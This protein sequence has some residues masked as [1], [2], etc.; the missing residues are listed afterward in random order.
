MPKLLRAPAREYRVAIMDS[1]RWDKFVPRPDDIVIATYP[2]CGTT[3]TQRI[4]DLL[5]FQN[6]EPRPVVATSPW[7]DATIFAPIE[8]NLAQLE[9]QTHRRFIKTHMPFDSV[10]IFEGVKYIHVARGGIDACWSMHNHMIGFRPEMLQMMAQV[11]AQDPRL[12]PGGGDTPKDPREHYLRW[13][14]DA[15]ADVTEGFGIDLPFFEFE[16]TYWRERRR[17][18]VLFVHYNDMKADLAG[19]MRRIA[20]FLDIQVPASVMP[21]LV[22]AATFESMKKDGDALVPMAQMAW[23]KGAD[24]FLNKGT[25]DRWKDVLTGEDIARYEALAARKWSKVTASWV[26]QGRL[27]AGDPRVMPD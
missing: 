22:E 9:A 1:H 18:N 5:V 25:N 20:E 19:E 21:Q 23:D 11:I 8:D 12:K 13:L 2:K 17:E 27:L 10:P 24:R 26:R 15:E 3:W 4:V 6:S 16:N 14:A 7:L